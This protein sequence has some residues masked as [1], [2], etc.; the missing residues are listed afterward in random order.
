MF[1]TPIIIPDVDEA[2]A[3]AAAICGAIAVGCY[4]SIGEAV[5]K[6]IKISR[7]HEPNYER[8]QQ[9]ERGFETYSHIVTALKPVWNEI[10]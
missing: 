6:V 1:N 9:L 7:V 5:N 2:G 3:L 8:H 10:G 4:S